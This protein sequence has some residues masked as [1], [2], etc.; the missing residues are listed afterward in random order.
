VRRRNF[1]VD[2][3]TGGS[4][5]VAEPSVWL[6]PGAMARIQEQQPGGVR[7]GLLV[8]GYLVTE[9][10]EPV[11]ILAANQWLGVPELLGLEMLAAFVM[12]H[13]PAII[14]LLAD[15][16]QVLRLRTGNPVMQGYEAGAD[17]VD[18]IVR[19]IFEAMQTRQIRYVRTGQLDRRRP[20]DPQPR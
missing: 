16:V 14:G 18:D 3:P 15:A 17:R 20:P 2:L 11:H 5:A 13:H 4:N 1:L 8:N 9:R 10:V 19:A 6:D 7:V 12:P